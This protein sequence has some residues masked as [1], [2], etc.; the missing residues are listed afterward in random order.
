MKTEV[1]MEVKV[2]VKVEEDVN[3]SCTIENSHDVHEAVLV[4]DET[5]LLQHVLQLILVESAAVVCIG[6]VK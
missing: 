1:K 6:L 3:G 2:K 4:D 5:D